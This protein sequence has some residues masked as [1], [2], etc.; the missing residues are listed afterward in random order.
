MAPKIAV[1]TEILQDLV[2]EALAC[3]PESWDEG[4]LWIQN[5]SPKLR[6]TLKS[7]SSA[8]LAE[9]SPNLYGFC[10]DLEAAF[11]GNNEFWSEARVY[12]FH[13]GDAWK[14]KVDFDFTSK[15]AAG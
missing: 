6:A 13:D 2:A 10:Q 11:R 12:F 9:V 3:S 8:E 15:R 14:Y 1:Y 5:G 4:I 7:S